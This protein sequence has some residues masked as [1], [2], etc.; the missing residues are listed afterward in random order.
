[1]TDYNVGRIIRREPLV[2]PRKRTLATQ[3][4]LGQLIVLILTIA[5][6]FGF[7]TSSVRHRLER[8]YEQRALAIAEATAAMPTLQQALAAGD[9]DKVIPDLANQVSR[10][11][12]ASYVVVIDRQGVRHSHPIP[13]LIG[14]RVEEPVVALDGV[15]HV[16]IDRGST[17]VSANGI[18]PLTGPDGALIGEVSVGVPG[19]QVS[20]EV[21]SEI[22]GL[23]AYA[24][25]GLGVGTVSAWGLARRLKRSTLGLEPD[26][27][28]ALVQEREATLHGIREGVV[29][30]DPAG[31]V[32]LINDQAHQLLHTTPAAVGKRIEDLFPEGGR[33]ASLLHGGTE[34]TDQI[35][36]VDD[37][38]LILNTMP[39]VHQTKDLGSVVTLRDRTEVE[40]A[41]RELDDVRGLTDALRAQQHEF[42]NRMH[43]LAGL[44]ELGHYDDAMSYLS[45]VSGATAGLAEWLQARVSN[46]VVVALIAAKT[47]MALERGVTLAV[48]DGSR[49]EV[50]SEPIPALVSILGNL[51]DNAIDA[52]LDGSPPAGVTVRFLQDEYRTVIEVVD[53]GPGIQASDKQSIFVDGYSTKPARSSGR[54][55]LGLALTHQLIKQLGG[56]IIVKDTSATTFTVTLPRRSQVTAAS[57]QL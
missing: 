22:L 8:Q 14:Q 32:T 3:I 48:A 16:R 20:S 11:T 17:G 38:C 34:G 1:M 23:L 53:T 6:G 30:V 13:A 33:L 49:L 4:L 47:T 55:G 26:E 18:A 57:V 10:R 7:Y 46:P 15:G 24:A 5:V 28:A 45:E 44:L 2:L 43:I 36:L 42:S 54:R 40:H 51:I 37:R 29:A 35:V 19:K 12:G 50:T 56:S 9:P 25:I 27:L 39:V 41:L 21:W 31:R 52:A